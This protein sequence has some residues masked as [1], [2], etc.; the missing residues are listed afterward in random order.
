MSVK[1]YKES[2]IDLSDVSNVSHDQRNCMIE[3][4]KGNWV[5]WEDYEKAEAERKLASEL[6][7]RINLLTIGWGA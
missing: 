1:R 3:A 7:E 2:I 4:E 6:L 5:H